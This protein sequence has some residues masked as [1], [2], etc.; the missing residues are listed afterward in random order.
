MG[1]EESACAKKLIMSFSSAVSSEPTGQLLHDEALLHLPS[2]QD[3]HLPTACYP[4]QLRLLPNFSHQQVCQ[5][6]LPARR[7]SQQT[8]CRTNRERRRSTGVEAP[9]DCLGSCHG[10]TSWLRSKSLKRREILTLI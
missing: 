1:A 8:L 2:G 4:V 5:V 10:S 6:C 9:T 7:K 3:L